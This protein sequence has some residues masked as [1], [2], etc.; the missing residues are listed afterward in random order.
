MSRFS[1]I[2]NQKIKAGLLQDDNAQRKV[3]AAFDYLY[4]ELINYQPKTISSSVLQ[5]FKHFWQKPRRAPKGI[6]LV[7][8]VGR[9]KSML[10]DLFYEHIPIKQKLRAHFHGFM[11]QIYI[12]FNKLK[13]N[14]PQGKDPVPLLAKNLASKTWLICFDEI[15]INDIADA[16]LLGR[17]F[18]HLFRLGVVVVATSNVHLGQLFQNKPGADAFK[19]FIKILQS[20]MMEIEVDSV[21]DYRLNRTIEEKKWLTPYDSKNSACLDAIFLRESKGEPMKERIFNVMGRSF[22]VSKASGEVARFLF[23]QLCDVNLGR[24][25]YLTLAQNFNV[26]I[27]DGIPK[28]N[29]E[30]RNVIERFVVLID[31]LYE[32][33]TKFYASAEENYNNICS[34]CN[35]KIF[36]KRTV[37]RL[38][39][40]QDKHWGKFCLNNKKNSSSKL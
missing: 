25:D 36:P 3:V 21:K 8:K 22:I 10:M 34:E 28:F 13:I 16:V 18:D 6:Y 19:P 32:Y 37:S 15:Q 35:Q 33:R 20:H 24:G 17:L 38:N 2:Y 30:E 23:K 5:N 29:S 4:G 14:F 12:S 11:Q 31:V 40:M 26:V 7:G 39:E 27:V 1:T 9:G